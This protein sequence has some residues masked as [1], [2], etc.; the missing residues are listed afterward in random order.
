LQASWTAASASCAGKRRQFA[1]QRRMDRIAELE[2]AIHMASSLGLKEDPLLSQVTGK[3]TIAVNQMDSPLYMRGTRALQA[4]VT[5]LRTR[6]SDDPFIAG[7]R[8]LQ[9]KLDI[10]G[11]AHIDPSRISAVQIDQAAEVPDQPIKPRRK[12]IVILGLFGGLM[13][14]IFAAFLADFIDRARQEEAA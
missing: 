4:E 2:E 7:L 8:D 6:K 14:G 3:S 13:L 9:E 11:S 10:L 1:E 5:S 12:M